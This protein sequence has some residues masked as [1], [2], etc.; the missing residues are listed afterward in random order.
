VG[1]PGDVPP[2]VECIIVGAPGPSKAATLG[3]CGIWTRNHSVP[4][5]GLGGRLSRV[6]DAV[7]GQASSGRQVRGLLMWSSGPT[8][9]GP[10]A[11]KTFR[12]GRVDV[13]D[14]GLDPWSS[15]QGSGSS[16]A[17]LARKTESRCSS[18]LIQGD[19]QW[20]EHE[21]SRRRGRI[22]RGGRTLAAAGAQLVVE[23][24]GPAAPGLC[25]RAASSGA[26]WLASSTSADTVFSSVPQTD[27]RPTAKNGRRPDT[28]P[29]PKSVDNFLPCADT[30]CRPLRPRCSVLGLH[31]ARGP[32]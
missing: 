2:A 15:D 18:S 13:K 17:T 5:V 8:R 22:T 3:A 26:R 9:L 12:V 27:F 21:R 32:S 20:T 1:L 16:S 28:T 7:R 6:L 11:P 25:G 14:V 10:S 23:T 29:I 4:V 24:R 31:L 30:A 19:G